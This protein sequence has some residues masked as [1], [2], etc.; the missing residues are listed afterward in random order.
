MS[1]NSINIK[2][3]APRVNNGSKVSSGNKSL[4]G[5]VMIGLAIILILF[6][7]YSAYT[8]YKNYKKY[9]PYLIDGIT[10][11]TIP[12]K[13]SAYQM[14][15]PSDSQYGTEFTYS[16]WIFIKD[17]N[18]SSNGSVACSDSALAHVFHKGSYDYIPNGGSSSADSSIYY[19]LLQM[20]GVWLYPNTNKL[21][22]RFNTYDNV[23]ETADIGNIPLNMWVNVIIILIGSSI[24]VYVNGNLK[25][26][27][28]LN[29]VPKINYGDFYTTNWGG[30]QGFLSRLRYF[31]YAIQP[32]QVDQIFNNGPSSQFAT[33]VNQGIT[34][35]SPTLSPNY[36]MTTGYPNSYGAPGYNQN[37]QTTA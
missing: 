23:V 32:F 28:K 4:F 27:S 1:S 31:N 25:K 6:F 21:N 3:N 19:P 13:F 24:D 2:V 29:G 20:P 15:P 36:W 7:I 18:F 16:F 33:N 14:P 9:S 12:Q 30:F 22:I 35:P 8:G 10:D 17:T 26:R 34:E 5:I 37:S 11:A